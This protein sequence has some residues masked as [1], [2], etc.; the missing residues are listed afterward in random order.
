MGFDAD[1]RKVTER[2]KKWGDT[3]VI[4]NDDFAYVD[5]L[6]QRHYD[7]RSRLF[8]DLINTLKRDTDIQSPWDNLCDKGLDIHERL[9]SNISSKISNGFSG[10]NMGDFYEGEKN[11]WKACK[12]GRIGLMAEAI[13]DIGKNDEEILKKLEEDLKKAH[14]DS[15]ICDEL[16]R[17]T[18][19]EITQTI[20]PA[21]TELAQI[22]AM[23][24][25]QMIDAILKPFSST[26]RKGVKALTSGN[27]ALREMGKKK[28]LAR[29]ILINN[30]E[31]IDKAK[32]QIGDNNIRNVRQK[33][34]ENANSWAGAGSRGDYGAEDWSSFARACVDVLKSKESP[35]IEK[36]N[37][38]YQVMRPN[39]MEAIKTS[40][41][42]MMSD[43][44]TLE[45][46]T[47]ELDADMTKMFADLAKEDA[48]I[49]TLRTSEPTKLAAQQMKEITTE[50]QTALNDLKQAIRETEER[51]KS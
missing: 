1:M 27:A 22:G 5:G 38:L 50:L 23:V 13:Y 26:I 12:N 29:Y 33:C 14:E 40:F 19:G 44:V 8:D 42:S 39:Y 3:A 43:P 48:V 21:L 51:M 24:G 17:K 4:T 35:V 36:A 28:S 41:V 10:L 34:E 47:G 6:I 2:Y 18:F 30:L 20:R 32:A 11:T 49:A 25:A 9:N 15:K 46:Y 31:L 45:K 16:V 7:E 37:N